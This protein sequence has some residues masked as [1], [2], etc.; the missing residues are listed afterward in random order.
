MPNEVSYFDKVQKCV[1]LKWLNKADFGETKIF[2]CR[3][4][5]ISNVGKPKKCVFHQMAN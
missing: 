2:D 1:S 4:T 5:H 3:M